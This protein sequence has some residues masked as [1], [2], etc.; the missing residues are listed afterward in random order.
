MYYI[1]DCVDNIS[2]LFQDIF[3]GGLALVPD[4]FYTVTYN[5]FWSIIAGQRFSNKEHDKLRYFARQ[6]MRFQKCIDVTGN[7]LAQTPWI[8]YFVPDY[9]GFRDLMQATGNML[10]YMKVNLR[11]RSQ[12]CGT[13]L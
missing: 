6:A 8:R 2:Y 1:T 9:S 10:K 12:R 3:S 13:F 7:A 5:A 4:L 11:N